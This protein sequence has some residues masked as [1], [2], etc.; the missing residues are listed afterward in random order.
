[1]KKT[2]L[3]VLTMMQTLLIN[4]QHEIQLWPHGAPNAIICDEYKEE[5][6]DI[7]KNRLR[8]KQVT[9]PTITIYQPIINNIHKA[10][11]ICPGGGYIRLSMPEEGHQIARKLS[12]NGITGIV[13]KYRLPSDKIMENKA[14]GPLQDVQRAI[15][16]IRERKQE[17]D[18]EQIGIMGFSAGGHLAASA[19]TLYA[20]PAYDTPS[21][22]TSA[23]PDF[24]ALIYPVISADSTI[25]HKTSFETLTNLQP[26]MMQLFSVEKQIKEGIAP[27]FLVH[28]AD[29]RSVPY[30]NSLL[31]AEEMIK[32][33]NSV[34]YHLFNNGEHGF[35]L[36][37]NNQN[38]QWFDLFLKWLNQL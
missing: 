9:A 30:Q 27:T 4:A 6:F 17:L 10:V 23:R 29:D 15:R 34:E 7:G 1:M 24:G 16:I 22:T 28:C 3:F 21:D 18:I 36:G 38:S 26:E 19:L 33:G 11:I 35:G 8:T 13:L 31:F 12:E 2:I 25:W 14:F 32:R 20:Y 5:T 37:N